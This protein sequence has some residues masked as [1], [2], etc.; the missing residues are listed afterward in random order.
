MFFINPL[1][2]SPPPPPNVSTTTTEEYEED[3][4]RLCDNTQQ[5][6]L[7]YAVSPYIQ[8]K[9]VGENNTFMKSDIKRRVKQ[10]YYAKGFIDLINVVEIKCLKSDGKTEEN[11]E[12]NLGDEEVND[13]KGSLFQLLM[14]NNRVVSL[15][16]NF[17]FFLEKSKN[18]DVL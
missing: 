10:I 4:I 12:E 6:P 1:K 16:V 2:T 11:I 8:D 15:K 13:G 7:I 9:I 3:G 5:N 18:H 17:F 14:K